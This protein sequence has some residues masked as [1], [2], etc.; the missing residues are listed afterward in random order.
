MQAKDV[1]KIIPGLNSCF[2][3]IKYSK[4]LFSILTD[5]NPYPTVEDT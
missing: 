3:R 2:F 4:K 5:T 1:D